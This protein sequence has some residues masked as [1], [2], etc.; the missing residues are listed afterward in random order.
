[1]D[2]LHS[3]EPPIVDVLT[4]SECSRHRSRSPRKP[5][6]SRPQLQLPDLA[7]N[8]LHARSIRHPTGCGGVTASSV[9]VTTFP[10]RLTAYLR[11]PGGAKLARESGARLEPDA[12]YDGSLGALQQCE[13]LEPLGWPVP[14]YGPVVCLFSLRSIIWHP[15]AAL[16]AGSGRRLAKRKPCSKARTAYSVALEIGKRTPASSTPVLVS[17]VIRDLLALR[18]QFANSSPC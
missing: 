9:A 17:A 7:K 6:A 10:N 3:C 13:S 15:W 14:V 1:M 18:L 12:V 11:S 5:L 8:G 2:A 4:T 16:L